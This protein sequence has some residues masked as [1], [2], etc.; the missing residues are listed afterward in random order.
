MDEEMMKALRA[1]GEKLEG[2]T[3]RDHG[4]WLHLV[5][6]RDVYTTCNKILD[7]I[8]ESD[9]LGDRITAHDI[10]VFSQAFSD[11]GASLALYRFQHGMDQ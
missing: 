2:L 7:F 5:T 3:G 4:P 11:L 8:Q 10:R 6:P 9:P 1:D